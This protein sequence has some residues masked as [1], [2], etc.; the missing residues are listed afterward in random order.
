MM[1]R[2]VRL[3]ALVATLC[4]SLLGWQG[5]ARA[6]SALYASEGDGQRSNTTRDAATLFAKNCAS[7]HG[8]DGRA[9][10]FKAKFNHAR[11][12]TDAAWQSEVTDERLFNSINNG[13]GHMPAFGKK[14]SESEIHGLVAFVRQ[15]KK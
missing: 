8:K 14:L 10:T 13:R 1:Y 5:W 6:S 15:L 11:N 12:L 4:L 3:V 9:K 7:C 2:D